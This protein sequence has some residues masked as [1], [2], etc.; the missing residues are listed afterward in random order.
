MILNLIPIDKGT[1]LYI[2][3]KTNN[4]PIP[5]TCHDKPKGKRK[6]R[7]IEDTLFTRKLI[8]EYENKFLKVL[9]DSRFPEKYPDYRK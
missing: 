2:K 6:K 3:S 1:A 8:K 5:Q 7:Y 4:T 9:Y